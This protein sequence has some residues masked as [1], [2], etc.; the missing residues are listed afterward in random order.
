MLLN[1]FNGL[2]QF[3]CKVLDLRQGLKE[4]IEQAGA[5]L[6]QAQYELELV[7]LWS[8]LKNLLTLAL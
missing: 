7:K 3:Q 6:C 1:I 8:G 5:G 4:I 2:D